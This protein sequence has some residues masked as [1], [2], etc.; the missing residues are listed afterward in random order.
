MQDTPSKTNIP[1]T[2]GD[3][4][5]QLRYN[6]R[7]WRIIEETTGK[8]L[9]QVGLSLGQLSIKSA[10][11]VLFAGLVESNPNITLEETESLIDNI[12]DKLELFGALSEA[13]SN[14]FRGSNYVKEDT[15]KKI[16]QVPSATLTAELTGQS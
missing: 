2:I 13:T 10:T 7:A 16:D 12:D 4:T 14:F 6:T 9:G 5:Y 15:K 3:K 1:I 8:S 11:A